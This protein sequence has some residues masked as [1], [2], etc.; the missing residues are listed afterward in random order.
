[1]DTRAQTTYKWDRQSKRFLLLEND[2]PPLLGA[3]IMRW[4]WGYCNRS[5]VMIKVVDDSN[6]YCPCAMKKLHVVISDSTAVI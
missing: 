6:Y 5:V 4:K 1:M 2:A 3:R